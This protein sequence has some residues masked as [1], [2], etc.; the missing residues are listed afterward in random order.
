MRGGGANRLAHSEAARSGLAQIDGAR[1][2]ER[3]AL[4]VDDEHVVGQYPVAAQ[5]QPGEQGALPGALRA[6]HRP[7]AVAEDDGSGVEALASAESRAECG[8]RTQVRMH[9]LDRLR[10]GGAA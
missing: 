2:R 8:D 10:R 4:F 7:G 6:H 5:R 9:E 1:A 3:T